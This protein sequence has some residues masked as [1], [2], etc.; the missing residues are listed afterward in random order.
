MWFAHPICRI[1]TFDNP[2]NWQACR[3]IR[4]LVS[5]GA[6]EYINSIPRLENRLVLF[7]QV[8]DLHSLWLSSPPPGCADRCVC[9]CAYGSIIRNWRQSRCSSAVKWVKKL[10]F[11]RE[12]CSKNGQRTAPVNGYRDVEPKKSD[13]PAYYRS[14]PVRCRP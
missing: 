8:A 6:S 13:L 4:T 9:S 1:K 5:P 14:V 7:A 12:F 2:E 3:V 10:V 11:I